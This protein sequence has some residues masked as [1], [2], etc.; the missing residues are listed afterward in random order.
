MAPS[1]SIATARGARRKRRPA[2]LALALGAAACAPQPAPPTAWPAGA[3]LVGSAPALA[4]LAG[5]LARMTGTPAAREALAWRAALPDCDVVEAHA[6]Q[7][8]LA[9]LREGLR[10][11][12]PDG[13]LAAVHRDRGERALAFAWPLGEARL[14]GSADVSAKGDLELRFEVPGESFQGTRALLR[15][16]ALAPGPA[17]LGGDDA[18]LHARLRPEG[19]IDLPALLAQGGQ[20]DTLFSLRSRVFS[21][22]VLDGT[23]ELALYL[24]ADGEH[25]PRAALALGIRH[26]A[27][28]QAAAESFLDEVESAWPL[29]R[30]PFA[31]G[32]APGA[33]LRDLRVLP[34]LA[35]CYVATERALVVG[36]SDA[37]LH[38]ALDGSTPALPAS[39]GLVANLARL[40]TADARIA[41]PELPSGVAA[42]PWRRLVVEPLHAGPSVGLRLALAAGAGS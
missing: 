29:Q 38:K 1:S 5:Q 37:S 17:L 13:A 8:S 28:A 31:I 41:A 23:W 6:Q 4:T 12:D 9:A 7:A 27:V 10:C 35:P 26:S 15:P 19:G 14:T 21:A 2:L 42:W 39:G 25:L 22:A 33:C 40:P 18:L 32:S 24:P 30:S 16:D 36:W 20:A 3:L 34:G 11:A